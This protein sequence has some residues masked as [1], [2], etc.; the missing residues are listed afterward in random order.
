MRIQELTDS[1]YF[2][3]EC[4]YCRKEYMYCSE[5]IVDGTIIFHNH[6]CEEIHPDVISL[7]RN[8]FL[9]VYTKLLQEGKVCSP[10]GLEVKEIENF[11]YTFP[12][13]VRF[14]NF[15][16][17]KLNVDY[18]KR[19]F[20][21]YLRGDKYDT[22]ICKYAKMWQ[23]FINSDG[24]INS[25][26]G[27]YIFGLQNQ[28]MNVVE[29]LVKDKDSRRASIMILQPYH[30][31][32]KDMKEVPCTYC[33]NFRIRENK[34]N[35]S[36]HMRSQDAI[37]GLGSDLPIFS[38]I[39]EMMTVYLRRW[40]KDLE[41]GEYFHNVDSFHIYSKHY[42]MADSFYNFKYSFV[43]VPLISSPEEVE[44]LVNRKIFSE[45][46]PDDFLFSK[47]LYKVV[48]STSHGG[49]E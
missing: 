32:Y 1:I 22:S 3:A 2:F 27:Q 9:Y 43:N 4:P 17:R 23:N 42:K 39:Q 26:Y 10:R 28:F 7:H 45:K 29:T 46:I 5:H 20:L 19:E 21:W 36:V 24:S 8:I 47:W 44:F 33:L 16:N 31:L 25:N 40:Y 38:F 41:M 49:E 18:I 30:L 13:Y 6:R 14:V 12:P 15:E 35:M 37:L 48:D 11:C 34:L